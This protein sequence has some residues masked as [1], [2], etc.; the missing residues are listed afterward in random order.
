MAG[1]DA[2][3]D[4]VECEAS[5]NMVNVNVISMSR[6]PLARASPSA[7]N[8]EG[9]CVGMGGAFQEAALAIADEVVACSS[10]SDMADNNPCPHIE[11]S[12]TTGNI[13]KF[14]KSCQVL[15]T[16]NEFCNPMNDSSVCFYLG[17][18]LS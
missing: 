2:L 10:S 17:V 1:M 6:S 16:G 18:F 15:G 13:G 3:L 11:V 9:G 4:N 5:G 7:I 12:A 14:V 8:L